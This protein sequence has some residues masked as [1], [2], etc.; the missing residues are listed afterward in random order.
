MIF[1]ALVAWLVVAAV[2]VGWEIRDWWAE[3]KSPPE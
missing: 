2:V 3:L 1:A